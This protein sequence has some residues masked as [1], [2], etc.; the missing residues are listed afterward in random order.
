MLSSC[1]S[2]VFPGPG[3]MERSSPSVS[4]LCCDPREVPVPGWLGAAL[5]LAKGR[6][7]GMTTALRL[8]GPLLPTC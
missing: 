3:L 2:P 6:G 4:W 5:C 1:V 7:G 8:T